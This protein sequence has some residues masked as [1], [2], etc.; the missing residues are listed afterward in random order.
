MAKPL[1]RL[2]HVK[3]GQIIVLKHDTK[4]RKLLKTDGKYAYFDGLKACLCTEVRPELMQF[5]DGDGWRVR[6]ESLD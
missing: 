5:G 2:R 1:P 6:G 3:P 4:P